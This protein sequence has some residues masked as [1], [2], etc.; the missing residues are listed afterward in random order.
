MPTKVIKVVKSCTNCS[1]CR[2]C[3]P[4]CHRSC[5]KDYKYWSM[6]DSVA[7]TLNESFCKKCAYRSYGGR[8]CA[9]CKLILV[10]TDE[11]KNTYCKLNFK[12][13]I[14]D[15][16]SNDELKKQYDSDAMD[17]FKYFVNSMYGIHSSSLSIKNVIFNDPATIVIWSDGV[18]TIVKCV[19]GDDF[20]PEKGLAMAIVKRVFGNKGYYNNIIKKW[21]PK[22][23][24]TDGP[25]EDDAKPEEKPALYSVKEAAEKLGVS[26]DTVRTRIKNG[27]L[28]AR[29]EKGRW[30]ITSID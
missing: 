21:L 17:A 6:N 9:G 15:M 27:K 2:N 5:G 10:N 13:R 28:P 24:T 1:N 26:E 20:D 12:E 30:V 29:K 22:E 25:V 4:S 19:D 14:S 11:T 16:F 3:S 7:D 23:D 18:K 8:T